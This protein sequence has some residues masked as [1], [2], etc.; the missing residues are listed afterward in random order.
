MIEVKD[1][2]F[3]YGHREILHG[4]SFSAAPGEI[5]GILGTNGAG[6]ST[7]LTC[8]ARIKE[9]DGGDILI[10]GQSIRAMKR[11]E[12]ARFTAY[13]P[14]KAEITEMSVFDSILL[15]RKPYMRWNITDKDITICQ[16]AMHD[17]GLEDLQLRNMDELSGGEAQKAMLARALVQEPK[18]LL[19]D[20][21][22]SSLDPHNQLE[23]LSLIRRMA[24]ENHIAVLIV[25]HDLN[26]A[27]RFCDR[28]FFMKDG[29]GSRFCR[30][31]DVDSITIRDVYHINAKIATVGGQKLV[32][33]TEED[34]YGYK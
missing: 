30:T 1:L 29:R 6:K 27:L 16:K 24:K 15:G 25:L 5:V 12:T 19:L 33:M 13:V 11:R 3:S 22:T 2:R 34:L 17:L 4:I 20:E 28:L 21:P 18:V 26:L 10:D 23:T 7:L 14:Q 9:P 31:D 8:I 32:M